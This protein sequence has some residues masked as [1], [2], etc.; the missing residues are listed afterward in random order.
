M[1]IMPE[2]TVALCKKACKPFALLLPKRD[3][4]PPATVPLMPAL[5][6]SCKRTDAIN[7]ILETNTMIANANFI[8][9]LHTFYK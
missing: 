4:A 3:S 2:T 9:Y 1:K 6:P 8:R 5:F 7:T